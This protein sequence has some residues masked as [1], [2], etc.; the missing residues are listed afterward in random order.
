M[1]VDER[2]AVIHGRMAELRRETSGGGMLGSV[3]GLAN[4][5]PTSVVTGVA[6]AQTEKSTLPRATWRA[7]PI[8]VYTAGAKLLYTG[9]LGPVAGTGFNI[10]TVS[11]AGSL[12]IGINIDPVAVTEPGDLRRCIEEGYE[13]LLAARRPRHRGGG[14]SPAA[15]VTSPRPSALEGPRSL[16]S[17]RGMRA[18][19]QRGRRPFSHRPAPQSPTRPPLG[20]LTPSSFRSGTCSTPD[21]LSRD[22]HRDGS[23][24]GGALARCLVVDLVLEAAHAHFSV[25]GCAA[26]ESCCIQRLSSARLRIRQPSGVR[27]KRSR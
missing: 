15:T 11:Y 13:S 4:L 24:I 26:V 14:R 21:R 6:R 18:C 7:S 27:V 17:L 19:S 5:L 3:A 16:Q 25:V 9:V 12:D 22:H 1:T 2:F 8:P 10:T 23:G 20:S